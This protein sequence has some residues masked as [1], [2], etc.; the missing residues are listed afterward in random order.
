MGG[1]TLIS[2]VCFARSMLRE[3]MFNS[4]IRIENVNSKH[5]LLAIAQM[6]TDNTTSPVGLLYPSHTRQGFTDM[7][8]IIK[9]SAEL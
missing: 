1:A 7:L 8:R 3:A 9:K 2:R 6:S 4:N 5:P